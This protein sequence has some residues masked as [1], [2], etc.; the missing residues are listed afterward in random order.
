[1]NF[2]K[3]HKFCVTSLAALSL[4]TATTAFAAGPKAIAAGSLHASTLKSDGTVWNWGSNDYGQLADGGPLTYRTAPVQVTGLTNVTDIADGGVV[5]FAVTDNG[6]VFGWGSN[7]NG[8]LGTGGTSGSIT[9]I[10]GLWPT[11]VSV[12]TSGN[13]TFALKSDGTVWASGYN[14]NG[15]L[16]DGTVTSRVTP[17]PVPGLTNVIAISASLLHT[18]ALKNDGTVWQWGV[19]LSFNGAT[20][21]TPT[22]VVG[23]TGVTSIS[24]GLMHSIALKAD[25]TVWAWGTNGLGQLGDGTYSS[26]TAPVQVIG[27]TGAT[28]ISAN[29]WVHSAAIKSDGTV[30]TWGSNFAGQLGNGS[31]TGSNIPVAVSGL[32]NIKAIATGAY[33]TVALKADGSAFAW[34]SNDYGQLGDGTLISRLTPVSVS[35]LP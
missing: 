18:I 13:S 12:V 33:N 3:F 25:G 4:F 1:M 30:W 2:S 8:Q 5:S 32:S 27:L 35:G 7:L 15:Q 24:T 17:A 20:Y 6:T 11:A 10:Q 22:Q 23:L 16:G 21:L 9:P 26:R 31:T 34:G 19:D 14:N 29:G 28:A